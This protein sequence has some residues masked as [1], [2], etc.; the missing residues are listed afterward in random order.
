M[1]YIS[2]ERLPEAELE[3]LLK[4]SKFK[5]QK[6]SQVSEKMIFSPSNLRTRLFQIYFGISYIYFQKHK[7]CLPTLNHSNVISDESGT[8]G[9]FSSWRMNEFE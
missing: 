4:I 3:F 1:I 2:L 8:L 7:F 5:E 9:D 6:N